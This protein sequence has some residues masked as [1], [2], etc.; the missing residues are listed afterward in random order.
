M[1]LSFTLGGQ[2]FGALGST[3]GRFALAIDVDSPQQDIKRIHVPG[4]DGNYILRGGRAGV[5]VTARLRYVGSLANVYT[6]FAADKAA[7][8]NTAV[9]VTAPGHTLSRC[10]LEPGSM[11]IIKEPAAKGDGTNVFMDCEAVFVS[12]A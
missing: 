2:T 4:T 11:K 6:N 10:Q 5:C 9:T 8:A 3:A 12:D 1:G 7:W